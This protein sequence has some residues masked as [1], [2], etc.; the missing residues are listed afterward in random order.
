MLAVP[1][2]VIP[3]AADPKVYVVLGDSIAEGIGAS[4][5]KTGGNAALVAEARGYELMNFAVGGIPSGTL[6][7]L[8]LEKENIRQGIERA[9]IIDIS[10]GGNDFLLGNLFG[11]LA[12]ALLFDDYSGVDKII[13]AYKVNFAAIIKEI[14]ALNPG[15]MLIVQ[16]LY[17]PMEG[18]VWI[19]GVYEATIT[20]LNDCLVEYLGAN[21]G[22]FR[23]AQVHDAFAGREGLINPDLVHPSDAGHK[24]IAR[25][26]MDTIDGVETQLPP[27]TGAGRNFFQNVWYHVKTLLACVWRWITVMPVYMKEYPAIYAELGL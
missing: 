5:K 13:A 3:Q 11:L 21:P 7:K 15:A 19:G 1:F 26:L 12:R 6:L 24:L 2:A 25:V 4:D 8:V 23:T 18:L 16:T 27:V 9:D 10:I 17:N 22:A 14:R 20:K